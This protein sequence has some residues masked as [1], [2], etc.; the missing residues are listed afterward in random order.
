MPHKINL[1]TK[2]D[3]LSL[4]L[5]SM[6]YLHL[7]WWQC[8]YSKTAHF[9]LSYI[10]KSNIEHIKFLFDCFQLYIQHIFMASLYKNFTFSSF[11][12]VL[13]SILTPYYKYH[14][15]WHNNG[16]IAFWLGNTHFCSTWA[17]DRPLTVAFFL[18]DICA[19]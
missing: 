16:F 3:A 6:L 7:G 15:D 19:M 2:I 14:T 10:K 18:F 11:Y 5:L 4:S 13:L 9:L 1:M 12:F 17:S 8:V